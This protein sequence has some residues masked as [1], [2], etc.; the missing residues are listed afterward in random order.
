MLGLVE[1][2]PVM[3]KLRPPPYLLTHSTN[4]ESL[5]INTLATLHVSS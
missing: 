2:K 1:T 5:V 4:Y 3:H